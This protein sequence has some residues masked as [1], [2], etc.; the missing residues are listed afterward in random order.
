MQ[1]KWVGN[2]NLFIPMKGKKIKRQEVFTLSAE[3][4]KNGGVQALL[5]QGL[6]TEQKELRAK[7]RTKR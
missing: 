2:S 7:E 6:I 3:E 5:K 1:Y 4:L